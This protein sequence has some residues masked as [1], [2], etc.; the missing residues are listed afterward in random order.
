MPLWHSCSDWLPGTGT[1]FSLPFHERRTDTVIAMG[2]LTFILF[3]AVVVWL[4]V[5]IDG[6]SGGGR[7]S[8]VPV[9]L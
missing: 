8:R 2:D 3:M 9:A 1:E 7:R 5:Q 4:A 6:G